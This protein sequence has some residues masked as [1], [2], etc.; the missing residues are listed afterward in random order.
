MLVP[1]NTAKRLAAK[2][3]ILYKINR[4]VSPSRNSIIFSYA[5]A[6]KVVNPPQ[7]PVIRKKFQPVETEAY[8]RD[9]A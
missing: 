9:E 7:K 4:V 1:A 3:L 5:K 8:L 2:L 6:E